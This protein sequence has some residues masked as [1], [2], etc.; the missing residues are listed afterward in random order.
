[1]KL[2][3]ALETKRLGDCSP[4]SLVYVPTENVW[5]MAITVPETRFQSFEN[6]KTSPRS[7]GGHL[8]CSTDFVIS[9]ESVASPVYFDAPWQA[10]PTGSLCKFSDGITAIICYPDQDSRLWIIDVST[11]KYDLRPHTD[12]ALA[13]THWRVGLPHLNEYKW[14]HEFNSTPV[15]TLIG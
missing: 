8:L 12:K 11:G 1:M 14:V 10:V 9:I 2:S 3:P 13:F 6:L 7:I 5:G 15:K 4:G